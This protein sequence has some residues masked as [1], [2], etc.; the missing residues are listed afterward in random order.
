[1]KDDR[2]PEQK[3]KDLLAKIESAKSQGWT[4]INSQVFMSPSK[5]VHDLS[6][7]NMEM[8]DSI[9]KNGHF[10]VKDRS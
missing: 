4:Y 6:A 10:L 2:T 5:T 7:A 9:E 1:M 3:Q 8:L